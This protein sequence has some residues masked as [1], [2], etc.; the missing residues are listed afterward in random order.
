[1]QVVEFRVV[2]LLHPEPRRGVSALTSEQM[3]VYTHL[4][5]CDGEWGSGEVGGDIADLR[6]AAERFSVCRRSGR[7]PAEHRDQM[8]ELRRVID[9]VELEFARMTAE[10]A[11]FDELEWEGHRSPIEWVR[12]EC[13]TWGAVAANALVVG[14]EEVRLYKSTEA[15]LAGEIGYAHLAL[16]A[17]TAGELT[18]SA[19]SSGFDEEALLHLAREHSVGRFRNDCDHVRHAADRP[20][21]LEEQVALA[22][23]RSLE[24]RRYQNGCLGLHGFLDPEGGATLRTALEPLAARAAED[25][26]RQLDRRLA[27]ALV[28]LAGSVL[29]SGVLPRHGC[30]RPHLHVTCTL[31]TLQGLEGSAAGDLELGGTIAAETVQRLACDA[32]VTRVVFDAESAVVEVGRTRRIPSGATRRA[33]RARDGGCTWPG[34]ERPASWTHAH[35]L[36]HW[37]RG[38]STDLDNLVL[39]CRYH[40]W[41]VHEGGW[42]LARSHGRLVALPPVPRAL[43]VAHARAPTA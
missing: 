20:S 24:F 35:H 23:A 25:D 17:R 6:A 8:I 4:A 42:E 18:T 37:A 26:P 30:Q 11:T 34:C 7:S 38:G 43:G 27:D 39:I 16:L 2:R 3:I 19:T 22:D 15:M 40:H 32:G 1:M 33:L 12:R 21:F 14:A 28:E 5:M 10:L 9:R 31:E 29:D 13:R 41:K 36:V